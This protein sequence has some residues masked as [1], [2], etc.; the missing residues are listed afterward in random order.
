[1]PLAG[2]SIKLCRDTEGKGRNQG[3]EKNGDS[4]EAE[5]QV[6]V[7]SKP[8]P[9]SS[10]VQALDPTLSSLGPL[11]QTFSEKARLPHSVLKPPKGCGELEFFLL[12]VEGDWQVAELQPTGGADTKT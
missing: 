4:L 9:D 10:G 5:V 7:T 2:L 11:L 8:S 6:K 3:C 1:M 12:L